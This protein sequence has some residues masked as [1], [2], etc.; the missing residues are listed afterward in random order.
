MMADQPPH[1][2]FRLACDLGLLAAGTSQELSEQCVRRSITP[3]QLV[4]QHGW[5]SPVQV[6][7]VQTL[8]RP[9]QVAPGYEVLSLVGQGGMG[10]VYRARQ[11]ALNRLVALKTVL[12][13]QMSA[14]TAL[15]R[16][17]QEAMTVA[18]LR[19]PNIVTAYDL[20]RHEGRLYFVMELV[21]GQDLERYLATRQFDQAAAWG[22]ARQVAAGLAHAASQGI[23]HRDIKPANLLLVEPPAGFP[24]PPGL[25]LV[26]ITDFGLALL[27]RE[28]ESDRRLTVTNMAVGSPHYMA[29]EQLTGE[30]VDHRADIYA[31]GC[32]VFHML[33]GQPP[34][35]GSLAQIVA[36]KMGGEPPRLGGEF[37]RS[38]VE[39]VSAMLQPDP[40]RRVGSYDELFQRID[41]LLPL[42]GPAMAGQETIVL[43]VADTA[44]RAARAAERPMAGGRLRTLAKPLLAAAAVLLILV[45]GWSY[46]REPG[47][48]EPWMLPT[49]PSR[50]LFDGQSLGYW[51]IVSGAW[52]TSEDHD[53]ATVIAGAQ[54]TIR[55]ELVSAD[56]SDGKPLEHLRLSLLAHLNRA[57]AVELQFG[58]ELS[59]G[60]DPPCLAVRLTDRQAVLV[61]RA[62][63]VAAPEALA[64]PL[65]L[66]DAPGRYRE[67]RLDRQ[68]AYWYAYVDDKLLGTSRVSSRRQLAEFRLVVEGGPAWFSDLELQELVSAPLR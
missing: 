1:D 61:R 27:A 5:L 56:S 22:L 35:E 8:L 3:A 13:S 53:R 37:S 67:L 60:L 2:F 51:T 64:G 59:E 12:L 25:P 62:S 15:A 4:L 44:A 18:R 52:S 46:L 39:L 11:K 29:P 26:K 32:T 9:D 34:F 42:I 36:Q 55:R 65:P 41:R 57:T 47:A 38:T 30:R 14:P 66:D 40:A 17:E 43:D 28:L 19:H 58:I 45:A 48:P 24:L 6:D 49:G 7:V 63:A 33:T 16:F 21:E 50:Y 31:L 23:V 68:G 20:G 54:G 10:V